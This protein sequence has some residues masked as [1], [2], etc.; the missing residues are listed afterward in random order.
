MPEYDVLCKCEA[1]NPW[2]KKQW[3]KLREYLR[4]SVVWEASKRTRVCMR[5][6]A[7]THTC[8]VHTF[9]HTCAAHTN[10]GKLHTH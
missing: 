7:H 8:G 1:L 6:C 3:A 10:E 9:K 4:A 5:T 2:G